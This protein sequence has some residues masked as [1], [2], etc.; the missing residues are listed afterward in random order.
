M[1]LK[2]PVCA[3]PEESIEW[4]HVHCVLRHPKEF[5]TCPWCTMPFASLRSLQNHTKECPALDKNEPRE[6]KIKSSF[7]NDAQCLKCE[8]RFDS[9]ETAIKHYK[10]QHLNFS[11]IC[12]VC[13]MYFQQNANLDKH[14]AESHPKES[15][16]ADVSTSSATLVATRSKNQ[17]KR[18]ATVAVGENASSAKAVSRPGPAF[19]RKKS[20]IANLSMREKMMFMKHFNLKKCYQCEIEFNTT[21]E[22]AQHFRIDHLAETYVC[23]ECNNAY[24]SAHSRYKHKRAKHAEKRVSIL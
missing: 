10:E 12:D 20:V 1:N 7:V 6:G 2:C 23:E 9:H 14:Y 21:P 5:V 18:S 3:F 24:L 15:T 11:Y 19:T 22:I 16:S 4:L 8:G 13:T 17:L